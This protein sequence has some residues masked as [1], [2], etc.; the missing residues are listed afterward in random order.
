MTTNLSRR[1]KK[2]DKLVFVNT[3]GTKNTKGGTWGST[4]NRY[5]IS[6]FS[7]KETEKIIIGDETLDVKIISI[8]CMM[9]AIDNGRLNPMVSCSGNCLSHTICYH[10]IGYLKFKL[11]ERS[12]QISYYENIRAALNGLNFGGQLTKVIS[13]QGKG[14]V[15]AVI[16]DKPAILSP[17]E[18]IELMRGKEDD[19]VID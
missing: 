3:P 17:K 15:W 7:K 8:A 2:A 4:G 19:E 13:K 16:K 5:S 6:L 11:A 12:K 18:N 10:S 9:L 1:I 14:F